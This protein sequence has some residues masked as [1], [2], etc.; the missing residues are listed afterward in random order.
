M[1]RISKIDR[2]QGAENLFII[3]IDEMLTELPTSTIVLL[4]GLAG[5]LRPVA[6]KASQRGFGYGECE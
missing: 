6:K 2:H 4:S 1:F 3:Y 5:T